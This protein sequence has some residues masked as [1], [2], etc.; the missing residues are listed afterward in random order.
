MTN[1]LNIVEY[2]E[3]VFDYLE[4]LGYPEYVLEFEPEAVAESMAKTIF[5]LHNLYSFRHCAL[6]I[7]GCTFEFQ[8]LPLIKKETKY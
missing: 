6:F 8:I 4:Y 5:L 3:K 1:K 2:Q 7:F